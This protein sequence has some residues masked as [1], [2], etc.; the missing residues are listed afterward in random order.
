MSTGAG[1]VW[2]GEAD[3][4]M[5]MPYKQPRGRRTNTK[6]RE[7][8]ETTNNTMQVVS[9]RKDI[10]VAQ[11]RRSFLALQQHKPRQKEVCDDTPTGW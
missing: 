11:K 5:I 9:G 3:G 6:Q 8:W 4:A 10:P 7:V 2:R 1:A